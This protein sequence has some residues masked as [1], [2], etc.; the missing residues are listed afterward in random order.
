[1][2]PTS[3]TG[4]FLFLVALLPGFIFLVLREQHRPSRK[5]SP[6][7]ETATVLLVSI[8]SYVPVLV[9][10]VILAFLWPSFNAGLGAAFSDLE[11]YQALHAYRLAGSVAASVVLASGIAALCGWKL[12]S[13][14]KVD[15]GASA[16]WQI[17]SADGNNAPTATRRVTVFLKDG[18]LLVGNLKSFSRDAEEHADR[19]L[20]LQGPLLYQGPLSTKLSELDGAAVVVSAREVQFLEV[21]LIEPAERQLVEAE[22]SDRPSSPSPAV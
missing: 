10:M 18:G 8:L 6:L 7:R 4:L 13:N 12:V 5:L 11:Q 15:P 14:K 17:L 2:I 16:W 19:D 9:A 21:L 1:V 22:T 20:V 3:L